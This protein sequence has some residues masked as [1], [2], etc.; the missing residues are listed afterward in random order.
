ME[1][2]HLGIGLAYDDFGA[3]EGRLTELAEVPPQ[4]L[5]FD[6][7]LIQN[8]HAASDGKRR[9]VES[10]VRMV[11]DLGV[12]AL[13]ECIETQQESEACKEV[14]FDYAQGYYFGKPLPASEWLP[15]LKSDPR[16]V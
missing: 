14:G 12:A 16:T 4:Y 9:L 1:L 3:G 11:H 10:L 15:G 5:K 7:K 6:R 2:T 8:L 13:A